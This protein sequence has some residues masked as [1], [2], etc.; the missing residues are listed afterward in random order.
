LIAE[1]LLGATTTI[2]RPQ[3]RN[4]RGRRPRRPWIL[5]L[6]G[7]KGPAKEAVQSFVRA[8]TGPSSKD[9]VMPEDRI[10]TFDQDGTLW[11]EHPL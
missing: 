10:A 5:Y 4:T 9:F 1:L 8:A 11:V 6:P 3:W 7:T 2:A